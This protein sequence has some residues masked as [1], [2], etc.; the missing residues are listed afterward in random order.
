LFFIF[1][2]KIYTNPF[3]EKAFY[4]V[5]GEK[6]ITDGYCDMN[7]YISGKISKDSMLQILKILHLLNYIG[8]NSLKQRILRKLLMNLLILKL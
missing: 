5:C 1:F 6:L 7:R 8:A 2:E 4:L 3:V